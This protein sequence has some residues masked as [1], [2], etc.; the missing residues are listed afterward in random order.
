MSDAYETKVAQVL[1]LARRHLVGGPAEISTED[2]TLWCYVLKNEGIH[3]GDL[4]PALREHLARSRFFPAMSEIVAIARAIADERLALQQRGKRAL[5]AKPAPPT[6]EQ[7]AKDAAD[8]ARAR[9]RMRELFGIEQPWHTGTG[10][11]KAMPMPM[12]NREH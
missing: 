9:E 11:V 8:A 1:A 6:P 4:A 5:K 2:V 12:D 10:L 7:L 3:V